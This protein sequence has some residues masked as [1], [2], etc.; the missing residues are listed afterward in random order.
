MLALDLIL[1]LRAVVEHLVLFVHQVADCGDQLLRTECHERLVREGRALDVLLAVEHVALQ[2]SEILAL[3]ELGIGAGLDQV[4][5]EVF[6]D[7]LIG[8]GPGNQPLNDL[9]GLGHVLAQTEIEMK[10]WL[11][12]ARIEK[13]QA[14][15]YI[16]EAIC[17]ALMASVPR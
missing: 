1:L 4:L 8:N 16:S 3:V 2:G 5:L 17:S 7:G 14:M 13:E 12:P 15:S 9:H 10:L 6:E 11:L